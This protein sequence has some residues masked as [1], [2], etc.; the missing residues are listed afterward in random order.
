MMSTLGWDPLEE[1]RR[2]ARINMMDKIVGIRVAVKPEDYL[3][4]ASTRTRAAN[5]HKFRTIR[6]KTVIYQNSFFPQQL[7]S[8]I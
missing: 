1:P 5:S 2:K 3:T 4:R 7:H 8:G 6:A